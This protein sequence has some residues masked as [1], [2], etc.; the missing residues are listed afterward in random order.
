MINLDE[1]KAALYMEDRNNSYD[2]FVGLVI[3]GFEIE[4]VEILTIFTSID[5]SNNKFEGE[6]LGIIGEVSSLQ[7]LNLSH[8]NL[9]GQIPPS[10][11]NLTSLEWLDLSSNKLGGQISRELVDLTFLSFFSISN[12]QLVGPIQQSK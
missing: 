7:G 5:L 3:K 2:Y 6:I 8:N 4:L 10:L 9:F 11:G 1:G 12:N